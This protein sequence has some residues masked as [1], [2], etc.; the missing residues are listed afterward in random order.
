MSSLSNASLLNKEFSVCTREAE[1]DVAV[2][3]DAA[4]SA[5]DVG[6]GR[7]PIAEI[8]SA[9]FLTLLGSLNS[10]NADEAEAKEVDNGDD[11]DSDDNEG[12]VDIE[13]EVIEVVEAAATAA[14][15]ACGEDNA[16]VIPETVFNLIPDAWPEETGVV[17]YSSSFPDLDLCT[18]LLIDAVVM[19]T[20]PLLFSLAPLD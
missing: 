17:G 19:K 11:N 1:V 12:I 2:A 9:M 5:D 13:V 15:R 7:G 6:N 20:S 18:A 14:D 16:G 8:S 10:T 3:V 4:A